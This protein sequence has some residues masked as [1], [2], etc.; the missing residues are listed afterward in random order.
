MASTTRELILLALGSPREPDAK[1]A[2]EIVLEA[3]HSEAVALSHE[4]MGGPTGAH[5]LALA[6]RLEAL[7][8]LVSEFVTV[9]WVTEGE[10]AR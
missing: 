9:N 2:L 8:E 3:I 7:K 5:R 6:C 4:D 1:A 10:A